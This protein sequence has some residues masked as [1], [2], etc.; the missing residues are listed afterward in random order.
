MNF[1]DFSLMFSD[2]HCICEVSLMFSVF[3]DILMYMYMCSYASVYIYIYIYIYIYNARISDMA[4]R[5]G[6]ESCILIFLSF[7]K[8]VVRNTSRGARHARNY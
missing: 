4:K 6:A 7:R 8:F 3:V 1:I 2:F 5:N